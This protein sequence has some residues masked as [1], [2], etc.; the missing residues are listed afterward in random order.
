MR[1]GLQTDCRS[2]VLTTDTA[3]IPPSHACGY[4]FGRT[5]RRARSILYRLQRASLR[6]GVWRGVFGY[7]ARLASRSCDS[8][9]ECDLDHLIE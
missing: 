2:Q 9:L 8:G 7:L 4:G 5:I 6:C 3:D 1:Q